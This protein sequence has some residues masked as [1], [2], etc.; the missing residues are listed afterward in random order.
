MILA[1]GEVKSV[2]VWFL[3]GNFKDSY[4][5]KLLLLFQLNKCYISFTDNYFSLVPFVISANGDV[6]PCR[7]DPARCSQRSV[8]LKLHLQIPFQIILCRGG[9]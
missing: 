4:L 2:N 5:L 6:A 8:G 7:M 9:N 1:R 3:N